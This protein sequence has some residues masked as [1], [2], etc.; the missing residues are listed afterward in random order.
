MN[1]LLLPTVGLTLHNFKDN[2]S[3][4][5]DSGWNLINGITETEIKRTI[6]V[7]FNFLFQLVFR[8]LITPPP[9]PEISGHMEFMNRKKGKGKGR[10][11]R[12]KKEGKRKKGE[13]KGKK[14]RVKE[15]RKKG[16][17]KREGKMGREKGMRKGKEKRKS[18]EK[19]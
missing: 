19:G 17:G 16:K 18:K 2:Q 15:K 4:V 9:Q 3:R 13:G 10:E 6:F 1:N 7:F 12:E 5:T 14:G 8:P 11:K